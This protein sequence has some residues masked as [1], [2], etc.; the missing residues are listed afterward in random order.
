MNNSV[1][2]VKTELNP[3]MHLLFCEAKIKSWLCLPI[4]KGITEIIK[5]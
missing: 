5:V 2:F 3:V 1:S 4:Y